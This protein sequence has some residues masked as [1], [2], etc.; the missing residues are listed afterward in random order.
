MYSTYVG[1]IP[2]Y[3]YSYYVIP[4]YLYVLVQYEYEVPIVQVPGIS[5][6][7][8]HLASYEVHT[9]SVHIYYM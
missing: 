6:A 4:P 8:T 5:Y 3:W 7:C 2:A 9:Y 1:V